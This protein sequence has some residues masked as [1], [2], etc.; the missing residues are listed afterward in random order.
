[1]IPRFTGDYRW[2]SN[3]YPAPIEY[4]GYVYPSTEHAYQAHKTLDPVWRE[5]IRGLDSPGKAKRMGKKVPIRDDWEA[6]KVQV[7]SRVLYAKFASHIDLREKLIATGDE[8]LIEGNNWGDTYWGQSPLGTG[9]NVLG[10]LL[11]QIREHARRGN[12]EDRHPK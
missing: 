11:M 12:Y 2:L 3:F 1:M 7:M 6:I 5:K 4:E 9:D 8:E 10:K